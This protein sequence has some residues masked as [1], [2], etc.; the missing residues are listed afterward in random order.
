MGLLPQLIRQAR[1]KG[2]TAWTPDNTP[3]MVTADDNAVL[4]ARLCHQPDIGW[5]EIA[6]RE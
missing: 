6:A 3:G 4:L 5:E 1:A 2:H